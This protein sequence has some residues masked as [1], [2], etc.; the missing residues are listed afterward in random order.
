MRKLLCTLTV[1]GTVGAAILVTPTVA[2]AAGPTIT[3]SPSTG[4]TDGQAVTVSATG[5]TLATPT[6]IGIEEC[7]LGAQP[8]YVPDCDTSTAAPF[9][10][11]TDDYSETYA[12]VR[13][14]TTPNAG[15]IDCAVPNTCEILSGGAFPDTSQ[16]ASAPIGFTAPMVNLSIVN[17]KLKHR[18]KP[19]EPVE[20]KVRAANEGPVPTTWTVSQSGSVGLVP[21]GATCHHGTERSAS[22][23]VH[24]PSDVRLGHAT[25][26]TFTLQFAP[27]FGG[28]ATDTVCVKDTNPNDV[29]PVPSD[30][31]VTVSTTVQ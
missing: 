11:S 25:K 3:V 24:G 4:L 29:D 21:V 20:I 12:V 23:C 16:E 18:V 14:I 13:H 30:N 9:L 5:F 28:V 7:A 15:V 22:E 19:G 1:L 8:P 27:G 6:V 31:C 2:V 17:A 10:V 26:D